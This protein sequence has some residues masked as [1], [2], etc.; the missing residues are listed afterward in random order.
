MLPDEIINILIKHHE[1]VAEEISNINLAIDKIVDELQ[2]VNYVFINNLS[3]YA[4]NT[5]IKNKST[6]IELLDDS[7]IIREYIQ[8]LQNHKIA[9]SV[10]DPIEKLDIYDVIVLQHTCK[11][12][13]GDH[14]TKDVK[15]EIPVLHSSGQ[16][17]STTLIAS[18]CE[19]CNKYTV[20]KNTFDSIDG[21]VMCEVIDK[22]STSISNLN[23]NGL[24]FKHH[25]SVLYRY[26]YNVK[27]KSELTKTQ[28]Q[29]ILS[30]VIEA[31]ILNRRQ[32]IDHLNILIDRG[33]KIPNWQ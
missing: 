16:V 28:R 13:F 26:G 4:K 24:E 29:I 18:Y 8:N 5:G 9:Y 17:H 1:L 19:T 32:V 20:L 11:C 14:V 3:S 27:S 7:Q 15:I 33:S 30:S 6:E 12:S 21:I 31:G 10:I 22:T 2:S 23:N 25:E